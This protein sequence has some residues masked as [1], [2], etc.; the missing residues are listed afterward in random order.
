MK[1]VLFGRF[2]LVIVLLF[3]FGAVGF[4]QSKV[5]KPDKTTGTGKKNQRPTPKTEEELKKEEEQRRQE[6]ETKTAEK[7]EEVLSIKTNIVNVDAVV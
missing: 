7:D 4:A 3:D 6:E 2:L 1:A 5:Q